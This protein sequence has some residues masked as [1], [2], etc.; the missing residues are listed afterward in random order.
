MKP[1][2]SPAAQ[3]LTEKRPL[4]RGRTQIHA[5]RNLRA[6]RSSAGSASSRW[7]SPTQKIAIVGATHGLREGLP[8]KALQRTETIH[9][10]LENLMRVANANPHLAS[11]ENP[12][13]ILNERALVGCLH[14]NLVQFVYSHR[15]APAEWTLDH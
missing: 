11:L 3:E 1:N 14:S 7:S 2:T 13:D 4:N 12:K 9:E 6:K 5:E 10:R 15:N 8:I